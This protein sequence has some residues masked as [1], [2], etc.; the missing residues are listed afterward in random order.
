M[1][2]LSKRSSVVQRFNNELQEVLKSHDDEP[3]GE[4]TESSSTGSRAECAAAN[5]ER[6]WWDLTTHV[7]NEELSPK[8]GQRQLHNKYGMQA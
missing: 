2:R 7:Y 4:T 3:K 5:R 1:K 6:R 8:H